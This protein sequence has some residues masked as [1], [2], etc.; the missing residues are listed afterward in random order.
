MD[1][2]PDIDTGIQT[3]LG[4]TTPPNILAQGLALGLH[5]GIGSGEEM[6]R[7]IA[8]QSILDRNI[9]AFANSLKATA[10][11]KQGPVLYLRDAPK[12]SEFLMDRR[13]DD[14]I[15]NVLTHLRAGVAGT[16]RD[17]GI[18]VLVKEGHL[19]PRHFDGR[20]PEGV[21]HSARWA[22]VDDSNSAAK[23]NLYDAKKTPITTGPTPDH[24]FLVPE[25]VCVLETLGEDGL[26]KRYRKDFEGKTP[27]VTLAPYLPEKMTLREARDRSEGQ[28]D[29]E[30]AIL[31]LMN[32]MEGVNFLHEQGM[33]H[34]DLKLDNIFADGTVF[35]NLSIAN[36]DELT[37]G[38]YVFGTRVYL[39]FAYRIDGEVLAK[40][41]PFYQDIFALAISLSEI[42]S[43][44]KDIGKFFE[45]HAW[46]NK[47]HLIPPFHNMKAF[48]E[49]LQV[50]TLKKPASPKIK[51]VHGVI[52]KMLEGLGQYTVADALAELGRIF[53]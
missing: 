53:S 36:H 20:I 45:S 39:P 25:V 32:A 7:F 6:E 14:K 15:E 35:D 19:W 23:V 50:M 13:G 12:I 49:E 9:R 33:V 5:C 44:S 37:D 28:D 11:Y 30:N 43:D 38:E 16:M 42:V 46:G 26:T 41:T 34:R 47:R 40:R 22:R 27:F 4:C 2:E 48:Y 8:A 29:I 21:N 1:R 24:R 17:E 52:Q 3:I 18:N 51:K 10:G 31:A